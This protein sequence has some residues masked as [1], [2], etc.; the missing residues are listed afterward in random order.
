MDSKYPPSCG[1]GEGLIPPQGM[2]SCRCGYLAKGFIS[3]EM[4]D[5]WGKWTRV[6]YYHENK[7]CQYN[8]NWRDN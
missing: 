1:W 8:R 3:E 5:E 6:T 7:T 4:E 2:V